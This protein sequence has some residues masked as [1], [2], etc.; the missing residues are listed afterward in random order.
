MR[1]KKTMLNNMTIQGYIKVHFTIFYY[2]KKVSKIALCLPLESA[3]FIQKLFSAI[4][5]NV[6]NSKVEGTTDPI[7]ISRHWLKLER[8]EKKQKKA[9]VDT[10]AEFE[11]N[12]FSKLFTGNVIFLFPGNL[13]TIFLGK[14]NKKSRKFRETL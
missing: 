5:R 4:L 1:K 12:T 9:A 2:R 14:C 8:M 7:E 6:I 13:K 10:K 3:F 11:K